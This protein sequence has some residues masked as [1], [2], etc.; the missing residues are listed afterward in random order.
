[1]SWDTS[2]RREALPANWP[3]LRDR[4]DERNPQR[5]CHWC[6]KPGGSDLDHKNGDR[7]DNSDDNLDWIHGLRA[8]E[9]QRAAGVARPR[10]CHG[11]KSSQEGHQARAARREKRPAEVHPAL[12]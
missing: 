2:T 8:V 1:M 9:R 7:S 4:A 11:E 6:G 10:N 3:E 5:I 12:R